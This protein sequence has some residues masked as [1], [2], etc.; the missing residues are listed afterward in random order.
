[1]VLAAL[2]IAITALAQ[3]YRVDAKPGVAVWNHGNGE[4]RE[5]KDKYGDDRLDDLD[6]PN[7]LGQLDD[8]VVGH[9]EGVLALSLLVY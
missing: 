1:M 8:M 3:T 5:C 7:R 9:D 6:C 4:G 2:W